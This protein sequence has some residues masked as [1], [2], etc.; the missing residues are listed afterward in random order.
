MLGYIYFQ[1]NKSTVPT[2]SADVIKGSLSLVQWSLVNSYLVFSA[3]LS[4]VTLFT[5]RSSSSQS[6]ARLW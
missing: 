4:V 1:D 6:L 2:V 5:G 3:M